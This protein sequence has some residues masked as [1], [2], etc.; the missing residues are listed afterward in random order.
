MV[1]ADAKK[2]RQYFK[3]SFIASLANKTMP[4]CLLRQNVFNNYALKTS[5]MKVNLKMA[6]SFTF[7]IALFSHSSL[8]DDKPVSTGAFP[9]A[10]IS[11][12]L[13]PALLPFLPAS[14]FLDDIITIKK[15][16]ESIV[17]ISSN[18]Q[19]PSTI[20]HSELF[21]PTRTTLPSSTHYCNPP[22]IFECKS[23][24]GSFIFL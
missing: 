21:E 13:P 16:A 15:Q 18:E 19:G 11:V 12:C 14:R 3:F 4:M 9:S 6:R 17:F 22:L 10:V 1:N 24:Y 20:R 7:A 5:K 2:C 23:A 8:S